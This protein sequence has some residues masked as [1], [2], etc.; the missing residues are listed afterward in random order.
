MVETGVHRYGSKKRLG[1]LSAVCVAAAITVE[2]WHLNGGTATAATPTAV[3]VTRG[4]LIVSVGGVGQIA[5]IGGSGQPGTTPAGA[6]TTLTTDT[7]G[8][9]IFPRSS[10]QLTAYLVTPGQHVAAGDPIAVVD[11]GGASAAAIGQA[12]SDVAIARLELRQRQTS[13]PLRGTPPTRAE[14]AAGRA[15]FASA[16]ARLARVLSPPRKADVS[17]AKLDLERAK[18][19]LET[20]LGGP[21]GVRADAVLIAEQN[22][23]VAQLRLDR[24]L[25]PPNPAD[26]AAARAELAKAEADLEALVRNDRTQPVTQKEI[27]A[28]RAAIEAA[29]LKLE[30]VLAP[31]DPAD[32]AA[33]RAQLER[34]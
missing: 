1:V 15:A 21:A 23:E 30:R 26:I 4:D 28:A 8:A 13:D 16:R 10:G 20:L 17:V 12:G 31:A 11:D 32:I 24:M 29:R 5:Q 6:A 7:S 34:T 27:D 9:P 33:A 19:D 14:L 3:K 18:A 22:V 25:A 2:L